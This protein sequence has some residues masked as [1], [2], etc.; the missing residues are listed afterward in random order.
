MVLQILSK[1]ANL[2]S[3]ATLCL[4]LTSSP[5]VDSPPHKLTVRAGI[6]SSLLV[7][8]KCSFTSQDTNIFS[9]D[10]CNIFHLPQHDYCNTTAA[11]QP[12]CATLWAV[13]L[14]AP[15]PKSLQN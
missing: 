5:L 15:H 9:L 14:A 4:P 11:S 1:P 6:L 7:S 3:L 2:K 8:L 13:L 10:V 12:Y